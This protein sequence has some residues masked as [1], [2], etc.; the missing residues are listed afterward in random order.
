[1]YST[2]PV[3]IYY[4]NGNHEGGEGENREAG[5]AAVPGR[6]DAGGAQRPVES[7]DRVAPVRRDDALLGA[8]PGAPRRD[9]EDA[10][11]AAPRAG[12]RRRGQAPRLQAGPPKSGVFADTDGNEPQAR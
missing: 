7:A 3:G 9:A 6:V 10:R 11:P 4:P 12:A 1:M 5:G 2:D 8:G